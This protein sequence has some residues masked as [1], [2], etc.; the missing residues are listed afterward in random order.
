MR[1]QPSVGEFQGNDRQA[2]KG[3]VLAVF[4]PGYPQGSLQ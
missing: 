3:A 4:K 2:S 1:S